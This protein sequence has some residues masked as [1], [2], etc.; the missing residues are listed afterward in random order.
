MTVHKAS[1]GALQ[2]TE[3]SMPHAITGTRSEVGGWIGP[4]ARNRRDVKL[5]GV[6]RRWT[7]PA[8]TLASSLL[9][10]SCIGPG[11]TVGS[12]GPAVTPA[13]GSETET[14][15]TVTRDRTPGQTTTDPLPAIDP[16]VVVGATAAESASAAGPKA[17][18][19]SVVGSSPG[20]RRVSLRPRNNL[21]ADDLLDHWGHRRT[22]LLS[23][24]L[25][26]ATDPDDDVADF[27]DLLEDARE[28]D[29]DSPAPELR[30]GDT[31]TVLGHHRGV[32]YGR[33]TGGPADTLSIDFDLQHATGKLREDPSVR[34]A[35]E[36]AGKEWS[37]RID[38]TWQAWERGWN[39]SKGHLIGNRGAEGREIRVGP[40]GETSTG[41]VIFVTG[42]DLG[43][44]AGRAGPKSWPAGSG[45]EPHTGALAIDRGYLEE[46]AES[47]LY[48]TMVHEIGHVIGSWLSDVVDDRLASHID[49][50]AG[51]WRGPHVVAVHGGPA[52]FQDADDSRAWHGGERSPDAGN[53]DYAQSGVCTSVMAY[54]RQSGGIP[55]F[56]PAEIDF[57]FLADLGLSIRSA[58]DRP[59]TYGLAGWMD[60]SA[61][62][63]SVS[64]ELQV[65]LADPQPRYSLGGNRFRSL[66]TVDLLW[67]EADAFGDPSSDALAR[68]FPLA[69]TVRYSG[70]LIG[71]AVEVPGLPPVHGHANLA[72]VLDTLTGK[73]SFTSLRTFHDGERYLFGDGSLHYPI[74][75]TDDGIS[76]DS[77]GVS[78]MADFYGP[79][80][81]EVAGTLDDSRAGLV[82]SFGAKH[83]E[84]PERSGVIAEADHVRGMMY[85]G[86][87]SE[88]ADGWHRFRCGTGSACEGKFE[89]WKSESEWYDVTASGEQTPRERLLVWTAGWGDWLSEDMFADYGGIRITRRSALSTDGG[90]GRY[91]QDGYYGT[92]EHVA[93]GTG[94][95]RY[96][97]W[98][99]Q[100]GDVWDFYI[101]GTGFQ[102]DLSGTLPAGG[103]TWVGRMVGY[104]SGLEAQK[105]PFVQG[106]ASVRASF[107]SDQ[108]DIGFSGVTSMDFNR[109]LADFGFEDIPL[110]ANG[111]FDG[112]DE[113]NVEGGFFGPANEEVAG[114]FQKN[115]N[116]V[117][118]SFGAAARD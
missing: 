115:A 101:R 66:D 42:A 93:F 108:V 102:G 62:T 100:D 110:S 13:S 60:H 45:W 78:L 105:D 87:F 6:R 61:F 107:G 10:A 11:H 33:W 109:Q 114:M 58:T 112:F 38:D 88:T 74:A 46:A 98:E 63:L 50:E 16:L 91:Q 65:S 82:A 57:A 56:L 59:E 90:T 34:A 18:R 92:M 84:R 1:E 27:A 77:P 51:T 26:D 53:I 19:L 3:A 81:E 9:V 86:G 47:S 118:G 49:L 70:G 36:R 43:E 94:F 35:L 32:S 41:L 31:V 48:A 73:A 30:E 54:C 7:A 83:D 4:D 67:A 23:A 5:G 96:H 2:N 37:Q 24:G 22:E 80:H 95:S 72:I 28:R 106:R 39:E 79:R 103:A 52:P 8:I 69:G 25:S 29:V 104:Q 75:V 44:A 40:G 97:D 21:L 117:I 71:T 20:G 85:Q 12:R 15:Q 111:T 113:G 89:W 76:D 14:V 55:A 99:R 116:N 17:G 64:R 68:S